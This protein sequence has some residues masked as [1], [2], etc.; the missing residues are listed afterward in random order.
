MFLWFGEPFVCCPLYM[1]FNCVFLI[2]LWEDC[3]LGYQRWPLIVGIWALR[4]NRMKTLLCFSF[5]SAGAQGTQL[6]RLLVGNS[7]RWYHCIKLRDFALLHPSLPGAAP[8]DLYFC[9]PLPCQRSANGRWG[10]GLVSLPSCTGDSTCCLQLLQPDVFLFSHM[11]HHHQYIM[12]HNMQS[13]SHANRRGR[14]QHTQL[15]PGSYNQCLLVFLAFCIKDI[16][17]FALEEWE[18]PCLLLRPQGP[19]FICHQVLYETLFH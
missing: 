12:R 16:V 11:H 7:S 19:A 1:L 17:A 13:Q 14:S 8:V 15:I 9:Q 10:V 5:L 6:D 4:A 18:Q 3:S 2:L